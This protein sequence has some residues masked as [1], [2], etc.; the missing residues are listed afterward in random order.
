VQ[1][2]TIDGCA[3]ASR[4]SV[5]FV[6]M[7]LAPVEFIVTVLVGVLL[8]LLE[9]ARIYFN[10]L[11]SM[12]GRAFVLL[13]WRFRVGPISSSV[14]VGKTSSPFSEVSSRREPARRRQVGSW[15]N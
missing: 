14:D 5:R 3:T 1:A 6:L 10:A 2:V 9:A 4:K 13:A 11:R 8:L 12:F 15:L 7:V